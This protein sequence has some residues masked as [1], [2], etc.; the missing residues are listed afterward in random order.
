MTDANR[1]GVNGNERAGSASLAAR[2][3]DLGMLLTET[4]AGLAAALLAVAYCLSFSALLFHDELRVGLA[5]GLWALLAGSALTGLTI[6]L[7]STLTPVAAGPNNPAVA[8]LIV[9]AASVGGTALASGATPQSAALHVLVSFS[10]AT[11]ATGVV[12]YVLGAARLGQYVRFVPYPVVGGFLAASG[13]LLAA[14]GLRLVIGEPQSF[15]ALSAALASSAPKL[16][17]AVGFA[18]LVYLLNRV[19]G[20]MNALPIAFVAAALLVDLGL[21]IAGGRAGTTGW[22]LTGTSEPR[23]WLPVASALASP[24]DWRIM[25]MNAPEIASAAAVTVVALLLD[26]SSLEVQRQR[27]ADLDREFR[28]N[29]LAGILSAPLGGVMGKLSVNATR[30]LDETGGRTRASSIV[31]AVIVASLAV[32][33]IDLARL[34]PAPVLAGLIIYV[35][36][37]VLI[38][39]LLR[40]P[41]RRAWS[42]YALAVLIMLAIVNLGYVAGVVM[43][44][45]G[46]C[47]VFALSYSRIDVVRRHLTRKVYA[48]N[49]DRSGEASRLLEAEGDRIHVFWLSGYVFFGSAHRLYET[50]AAALG[51]SCVGRRSFAVLDLAAVTGF[52]TSAL[53][54]LMKLKNHAARHA[55]VLAYAGLDGR[56]EAAFERLG[57]VGRA[58]PH[59]CFASRDAALAWC[60]D[61]MLAEVE[62]MTPPPR[63][64]VDLAD[65]LA[66]E[67]GGSARAAVLMRYL[68]RQELAPDAELYREDAAAD[69]IDLVSAGSLTV[70]VGSG[71]GRG[72][73]LRRMA[74]RT[75]VGEM[76]FFRHG[77]RT[78][79]VTA[80][81]GAVVYTLT[82]DAYARLAAEEP[83]AAGAFL[84]FIIRALSDRLEFAN[85]SLSALS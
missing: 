52:D 18:G 67:T 50:M 64:S 79:T 47:L 60:E 44:F 61:E 2:P 4:G 63:A 16:A 43:G 59:K 9:L 80:E 46:A 1:D 77:R 38:D 5:M 78:A 19:S 68:V 82:R 26:V 3:L 81:P 25:W 40:S 36:A 71:P 58:L 31:A 41:A 20:R 21:W 66:T 49:V 42:D 55:L 51:G 84:E 11:L 6:G 23:T 75:V 85:T 28:L 73:I 45:V 72:L 76:G 70:T 56:T 69:T 35:G 37:S 8:V 39:V 29:G 32:L 34:V 74:R 48:S 54:S 15:A 33:G 17:V 57:L 27:A 12:L 13:W 7:G 14:G 65:W 53:L 83:E 10:L 62:S 30:L 24:I 22:Y